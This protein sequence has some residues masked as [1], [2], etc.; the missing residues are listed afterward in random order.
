[1]LSPVTLNFI[2]T[3]CYMTDSFNERGQQVNKTTFPKNHYRAAL[4]L[5]EKIQSAIR[6]E[7]EGEKELLTTAEAEGKVAKN[8]LL[9]AADITLTEAEKA[10]ISQCAKEATEYPAVDEKTLTEFTEAT[11]VSV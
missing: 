8:T 7:V 10:W 5:R 1:M 4:S 9:I 2:R 3:L 11:G 6:Y